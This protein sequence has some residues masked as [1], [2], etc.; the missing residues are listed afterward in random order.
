MRD[1]EKNNCEFKHIRHVHVHSEVFERFRE[2]WLEGFRKHIG[3]EKLD[4]P[5]PKEIEEIIRYMFIKFWDEQ[6]LENQMLE[7]F[8]TDKDC[9][10]TA[11]K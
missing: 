9:H 3:K 5:M 4:Y 7:V 1:C 10:E 11:E 2:D 6:A 8:F